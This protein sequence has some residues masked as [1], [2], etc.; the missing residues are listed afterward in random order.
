MD[1][2]SIITDLEL[3]DT[4]DLLTFEAIGCKETC[5]TCNR[6]CD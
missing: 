2:K 6:K 5:P 1:D 3:S 4:Y